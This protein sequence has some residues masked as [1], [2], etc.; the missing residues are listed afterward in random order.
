MGLNKTKYYKSPTEIKKQMEFWF[1]KSHS[2]G[3]DDTS[4]F[5]LFQLLD[6]ATKDQVA[7][8]VD[9]KNEERIVFVL[10][11]KNKEYIINTTQRFIKTD[12]NTIEEINYTNF[13][14]ISLHKTISQQVKKIKRVDTEYTDC[15]LFT[16]NEQMTTW[17]IRTRVINSF[18]QNTKR[19]E[20]I[21]RKY[22]I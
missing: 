1:Y 9:L 3:I 6:T 17:R 11:N 4:R 13:K 21:G 12:D 16:N 7:Q 22:L 20:L 14:S 5:T 10:F 15:Y 2:F 8:K 18:I 19:C